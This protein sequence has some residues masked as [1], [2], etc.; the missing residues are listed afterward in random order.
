MSDAIV[1]VAAALFAEHGIR[2]VSA[3]RVLEVAGYSKVTFYRHFPSKDALVVAYLEGELARVRTLLDDAAAAGGPGS[4]TEVA[5]ALTEEMCRPHFR[6][7]PFINAAAEYP[8]PAHP[9]RRVVSDFRSLMTGAIAGWVRAR[10]AADPERLAEQIMMLRD[11]ALVA[12]YLSS[13]PG[14]VARELAG[15]LDALLAAAGVRDAG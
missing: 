3:D 10:G 6:G 9:V 11:G 5:A 4:T 7:C 2:A 1:D 13:D 8:D 12:G 14:L 15:S